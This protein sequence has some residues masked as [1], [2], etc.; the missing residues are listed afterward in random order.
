LKVFYGKWD[1]QTEVALKR[2]KDENDYADFKV[3]AEI[4]S[5]LVHPNVILFLGFHNGLDGYKY[6][7]FEYMA[8]GNLLDLLQKKGSTLTVNDLCPMIIGAINGMH[9]L[10]TKKFLH[11]DLAARNLLV[12]KV[13]NS[14]SV[15]VSDFGL[16]RS[17]EDGVYILTEKSLFPTRW[18]APEVFQKKIFLV[19]SD[20]W[21]MGVVMWEIFTKGE[22]PYSSLTNE[23][24]ILAVSNGE[25]LPKPHS[26]PSKYWSTMNDCWSENPSDRPSFLEM[27]KQLTNSD[28][29]DSSSDYRDI[30]SFTSDDIDSES[31]SRT[32]FGISS[33][34]EED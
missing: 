30:Y 21:S 13:M 15:K 9:Y 4:L 32:S 31:S 2:L 1:G 23:Q 8:G 20:V 28:D 10:E 12:Q 25:R 34:K 11:R 22:C 18:T 26:C 16:S 27:A 5:R 6:L 7:V 17:S 33:N 14:W 29:S 24:V 3:E 19:K